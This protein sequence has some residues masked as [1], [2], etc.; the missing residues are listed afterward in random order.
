MKW[1]RVPIPVLI[2]KTAAG[3]KRH[4]K[5]P[6]FP[7]QKYKVAQELSQTE[8]KQKKIQNAS[9]EGHFCPDPLRLVLYLNI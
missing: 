5:Y 8:Q 3:A 6:E 1:M 9:M 2:C 4:R 7:T